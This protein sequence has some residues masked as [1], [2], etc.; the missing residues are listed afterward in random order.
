MSQR[1]TAASQRPVGIVVTSPAER[2]RTFLDE[3]TIMRKFTA[4]PKTLAAVA[5][6]LAVGGVGAGV[7]T[8]TTVFAGSEHT[9]SAVVDTPEPGDTPDQ[10][11]AAD[12]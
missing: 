2:G 10:P 9:E 1:H 11:G 5:V 7:A 6:V 8:A 12:R 3:R 4:T